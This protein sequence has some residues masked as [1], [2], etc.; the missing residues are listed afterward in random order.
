MAQSDLETR[1]RALEDVEAIKVLKA[2]YC[3]GVDDN[4]PDRVAQLFLQDAVW[5][6]P[7]VGRFEGRD[8]I[9]KFMSSLPEMMRFWLHLVMNPQIEVSGDEARGEWYLIEPNTLKDGTAV[10]GTGRYHERYRRVDGKWYF[11][12][13][14]LLPV[15]WSPYEEGW[16]KVPSVFDQVRQKS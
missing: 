1:L 4:D 5:H 15:F 14:E 3:Y 13:V 7:G 9:H 2:E 8:S 10:W 12:E 11:E 16:A 6:A